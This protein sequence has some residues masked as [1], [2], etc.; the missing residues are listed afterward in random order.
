VTSVADIV[1]FNENEGGISLVSIRV[2]KQTNNLKER[3]IVPAWRQDEV[4]VGIPHAAIC[5]TIFDG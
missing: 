2:T 5:A 3:G 4:P 1:Y